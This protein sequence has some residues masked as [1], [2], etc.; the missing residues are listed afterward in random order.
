[1]NFY[2][3]IFL[4]SCETIRTNCGSEKSKIKTVFFIC[5]FTRLVLSLNKIG[6]GS[7]IKKKK[8]VFSFCIALAFHYLCISVMSG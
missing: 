1:M 3:L 4:F 8:S 7:A 5:L 6:G 2:F